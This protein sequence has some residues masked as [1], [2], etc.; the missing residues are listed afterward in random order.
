MEEKRYELE[1]CTESLEFNTY[2][3]AFNTYMK[4]R[5]SADW[6]YLFDRVKQEYLICE[7]CRAN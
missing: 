3:S 4:I 1:T 5:D 6:L 2:S 7:N